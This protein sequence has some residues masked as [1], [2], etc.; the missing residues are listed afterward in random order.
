MELTHEIL[1]EI[2][3]KSST[4]DERLANGYFI[5]HPNSDES[6][7][8]RRLNRWCEV[9]AKGNR[10]QFQ[11]LLLLKGLDL[12]SIK[13]SLG[14]VRLSDEAV[15][16]DWT[17]LL[18]EGLK[19]A[20]IESSEP[21]L[22]PNPAEPWP[23]EQL[24]APFVRAASQL[25]R[26][27]AG[28]ARDGLTD[29]A[30]SSLE[31][32]LLYW[33]VNVCGNAFMLEFSIFRLK[34]QPALGGRLTER[35]ADG[36]SEIY[37]EFCAQMLSGGLVPFFHEYSGLARAVAS[38]MKN[39]LDSAAEFLN[40]L[41]SDRASLADAFHDG[42]DVGQVDELSAGLSDPHR[43]GRSVFALSF[44]S[45]LKLVYKPK[46]L[47]TEHAYARL[48][49]WIN[50]HDLSLPLKG[51]RVLLRPGYGWAEFVEH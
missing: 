21:F 39:W 12:R 28:A 43:K 48:V 42:R 30:H 22:F 5:P 34:R 35:V 24:V 40:R 11:K 14:P 20:A 27:K 49:E 10:E 33:L 18:Q 15:L 6:E 41:A 17:D 36:S 7:I 38:L 25:L 26:S 37:R 23:F 8:D 45:G 47:E 31:R 50:C 32:K 46:S 51:V 4:C 44:S 16:P 1:A 3:A 19:E 29:K 13:T 9:A 2:V